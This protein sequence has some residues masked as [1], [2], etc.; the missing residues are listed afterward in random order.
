[1]VLLQLFATRVNFN[2]FHYLLLLLLLLT[3]TTAVISTLIQ[4]TLVQER[5]LYWDVTP[6][7][8]S[9]NSNDV[10]DIHVIFSNH[11]DVGFNSRAW[12][13]GGSLQG[14]IGPEITV[15]G[16][17]CRPWSY[18][19]I[20]ANMN[21]FLPR[22]AALATKLRNT[23]TKFTYMTQPF[24]VSFFMDCLE[25]GLTNWRDGTEH[26]TLLLECPSKETLDLFHAAVLRGDIWWHAFPHNP[27]PG[28]YDASLFNSSLRIAMR[29]SDQ[30]G[31]R[32][33]TTYSQR[34]ETGITRAIVP[35]LSAAGVG[36]VSLGSGG[37]TGG[38]PVIPDLFIWKDNATNTEVLFMFDHGY[39]GGLHV[40]PSNGVAAYCAWNTDNGGPMD[41]RTVQQVYQDLRTKY[42][43]ANVHASTFDMVKEIF[44]LLIIFDISFFENVPLT[45][46]FLIFFF[47][48]FISC[49]FFIM[50]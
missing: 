18:Y 29:H 38:H 4:E 14:C 16:Q 32:R 48:F 13:D 39:G 43:N 22:A 24:I 20:N 23:T 30:L 6:F 28:L 8:K 12:C 45:H 42:P 36:M 25:S 34:D 41:Q 40:L 27:M 19:V 2:M 21:T 46:S 26:G 33:P 9:V 31:V 7:N 47:F 15:D 35:L 11:L 49:T 44:F 37:G 1:M 17:R 5:G 3:P 10:V 50:I